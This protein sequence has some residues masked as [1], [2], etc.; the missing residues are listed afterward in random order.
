[1]QGRNETQGEEDALPGMGVERTTVCVHSASR[2][3]DDQ[4]PGM[5]PVSTTGC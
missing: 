5:L 2:D 3:A 4:H 1:M